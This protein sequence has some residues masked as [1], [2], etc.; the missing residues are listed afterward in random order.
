MRHFK[1]ISKC[2]I[3]N[4]H[5]LKKYLDLGKQPLANS[6][7]KQENI[8]NEKKYPLELIFCEKCKLSQLSVVV[9]PKLIFNKYDYLASFSKALKNHYQKLVKSLEK[10]NNLDDKTT[11]VD[12]GCN[13]GVLLNNYSKRVSNV[14][15]IEPSD[16]F[17]KIKNKK[18]KVINK[19]FNESTVNIFLKKFSK[20]KIITITNVLAHVDNINN[21]IK[22][23]KKILHSNG[24]LIIE[25]PY[26]LDMLNRSTFDL[27]Y[28]EHLSYFNIISLQF[29]FKKNDLKIIN[30]DK[31]NF[32][33]SGPSLRIY[34]AH[35]KSTFKISKKISKYIKNEK[36]KGL[37]NFKTY[38]KFEKNVKNKIYRLKKKLINL[39]EKNY[40]LACF[41]APAKG[42]TLLNSLNLKSDFFEFVTENNHRKINKF[43]PGTHLKI[44]KDEKLI[45]SEIKYALLLSWN[46]KKFFLKNSKFIKNGGKFI[47]PF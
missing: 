40:K 37:E 17:K 29:L 24:N 13:D 25:V 20:A 44:V 5:R 26:I 28:H 39:H 11:V 34:V 46:Y 3:C 30:I 43:T 2:R 38:I 41:T 10:K 31:I 4:S 21:L 6:F 36:S 33:A 42:N 18:I 16:A 8:K 27:V 19:F 12:I 9:N 35:N 14:V 32:G 47:F 45:N 7:L 1:K 15:G 23:I 22:N